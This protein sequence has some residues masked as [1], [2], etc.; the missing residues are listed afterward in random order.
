MLARF[1]QGR[2]VEVTRVAPQQSSDAINM[3]AVGDFFDSL[4]I[5]GNEDDTVLQ[6]TETPPLPRASM[7]CTPRRRW[8]SPRAE[9]P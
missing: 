7:Q 8:P 6:G 3:Q 4:G 5:P 9:A 1:S 2:Y